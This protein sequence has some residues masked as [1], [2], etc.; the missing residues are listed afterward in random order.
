[1]LV[2]RLRLR[3]PPERCV[4]AAGAQFVAGDC[5]NGLH[6]TRIVKIMGGGREREKGEAPIVVVVLWV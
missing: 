5:A 3:Q 6:V 1:M 2:L 4:T